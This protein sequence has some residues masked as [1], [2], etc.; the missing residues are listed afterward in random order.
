VPWITL[1][2]AVALFLGVYARLRV[3]LPY[4]Q[5]ILIGMGWP[6]LIVAVIG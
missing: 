2:V 1:Y 4:W 3:R 5:S 6:L